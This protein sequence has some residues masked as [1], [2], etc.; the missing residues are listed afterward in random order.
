MKRRTTE[1]QLIS[2]IIAELSEEEFA[3]AETVF[4]LGRDGV[5]A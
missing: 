2:E 1:A 5:F 4:Y 3:D